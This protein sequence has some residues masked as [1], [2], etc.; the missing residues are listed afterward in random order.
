MR[1]LFY[2]IIILIVVLAFVLVGQVFYWTSRIFSRHWA[3]IIHWSV[4]GLLIVVTAIASMWGH[5]VTRYQLDV[6]HI[7]VASAHLP[8][9][10]DG[11]RIAQISD[12]H[13]DWFDSVPGHRFYDHVIE[14]LRIEQPDMIVFTGDLVTTFSQEAAPFRDILH[15]LAHIQANQSQ[16]HGA[17][18]PVYSILG[19]HDYA[20]YTRMTQAQKNADVN[21]LCRMQQ[22]SGWRLLRNEGLWIDPLGYPVTDS[23]PQADSCIALLGIDNIGEPPFSTYG[24]LSKAQQSLSQSVGAE[25]SYTILLSHNPTHWRSEVL[26]RTDIDLMLAGH[27]H[28]VQLKLGNWSPA[29]WKYPEWA[30]LYEASQRLGSDQQPLKP[31]PA[32]RPQYLYVNT[33]IGGVG[34]RV[35]IGVAPEVTILTLKKK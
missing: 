2:A 16:K 24:D 29:A 23:V 7:E 15:R 12:M 1:I 19:N 17:Y 26:P 10:F 28:A 8:E 31:T 3:A 18:I 25:T 11:L 4:M 9:A 33:G 13:L 14:T 22:E 20:D 34:P 5:W 27:T 30:G 32:T 21:R 6:K 35:R